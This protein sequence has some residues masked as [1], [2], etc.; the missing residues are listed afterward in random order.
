M[1]F[2]MVQIPRTVGLRSDTCRQGQRLPRAV[3]GQVLHFGRRGE[4]SPVVSNEGRC[5][6]RVKPFRTNQLKLVDQN[7]DSWTQILD[8]FGQ[9]GRLLNEIQPFLGNRGWADQSGDPQ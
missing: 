9:L 5:G 8:A 7:V 4:A 6:S 1:R 2:G 3:R